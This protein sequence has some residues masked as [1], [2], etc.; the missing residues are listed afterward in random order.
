MARARTSHP[1]GSTLLLT[2]VLL[3]VL[4]V[5]GVA[6][7][8]LGTQERTNA[9]AK[10]KR[11]Y[12]VACANA[13]RLQVWAELSKR[14]A[15]YLAA[16]ELPGKIVLADGTELEAPSAPTG[17]AKAGSYVMDLV[18]VK[19]ML[20][21]KVTASVDMTN[22]M[23]NPQDLNRSAGNVILARCRDPK[24]RELYV[25]FTTKFAL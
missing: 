24:G 23:V 22:R 9:A 12:L 4:T 3:V 2:V 15:D 6:A 11:D 13:A 17:S 5:M 21:T 16:A 25:E 7:I 14:G 10:E 8:R 19:T 18:E 20:T 1:R